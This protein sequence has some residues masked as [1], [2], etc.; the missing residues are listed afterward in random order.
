VTEP[1]AAPPPLADLD[2]ALV[3]ALELAE[4][5]AYNREVF[6]AAAALDGDPAGARW[7]EIGGGVAAALTSIDTGFFN[8]VVGLGVAQPA[9]EGDVAAILDFYTAVDR[10]KSAVQVAP[11]AGPPQ[12]VDWLLAA[13]YRRSAERTVTLWHELDA[14]PESLSSLR[15]ERIGGEHAR[16]FARLHTTASGLPE[17]VAPLAQGIVGREGWT[18]Y[19]GFDGEQPVTS[20]ALFIDG[21]WAWLG[22]AA[23]LP[24]HRGRG[25][26]SAT[27]AARLRHAKDA[28]V[29]WALTETS[30]ETPAA[31]VNPSYRNMRRAGFHLGYERQVH[32]SD[33]QG[34]T[35]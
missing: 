3:R 27:L 29:R 20:A 15:I 19:L 1:T 7:A 4:A 30:A 9:T 2:P 6:A 34:G 21:T 17:V 11:T 5:I 28:G 33:P 22:F 8:R 32:V 23:T 16:D 13:G 14:L 10:T 18:C 26:Q 25:G 31:P 35:A 12:L 24:S